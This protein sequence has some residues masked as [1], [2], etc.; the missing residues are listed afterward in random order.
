MEDLT[1]L[2]HL[3][4][5]PQFF[6]LIEFSSESGLPGKE[7]ENEGAQ[8][9]AHLERLRRV[10]KLVNTMPEPTRGNSLPHGIYRIPRG[11][12]QHAPQAM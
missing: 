9:E 5:T 2:P 1:Q 10:G 8:I 7:V 3:R 11:V 6:D 4:V 12:G